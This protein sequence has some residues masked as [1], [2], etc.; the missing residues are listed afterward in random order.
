MLLVYHLQTVVML[1]SC[2]FL[3]QCNPVVVDAKDISP[4]HRARYFWGNIPGMNRPAV[5]LPGDRLF[6]QEC[7]EENCE[8]YAQFSKLRTI[9]TKMNSIKQG[10]KAKM[11]VRV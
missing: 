5:A 11:P 2:V 6:L 3:L 9:T 4:T 1:Q 10:K 8:R 7:L